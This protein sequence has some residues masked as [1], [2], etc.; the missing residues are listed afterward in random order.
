M[1]VIQSAQALIKSC[2]H[3]SEF[4]QAIG[5]TYNPQ[6]P[7]GYR[8]RAVSADPVIRRYADGSSLRRCVF[9][10]ESSEAHPAG[11]IDAI[12]DSGFYEHFAA[13]LEQQ[14]I[15]GNLPALEEGQHPV[16]LYC[17]STGY[18]EETGENSYQYRIECN[19][20]YYQG[21]N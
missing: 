15:L 20:T 17:S 11:V 2:P 14:A 18:S 13:W 6:A 4:V 5:G 10:F 1:T 16:A 3:L 21:G 9:L 8:I 7:S 12:Q 19:L